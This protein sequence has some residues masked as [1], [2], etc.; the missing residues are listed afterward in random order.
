MAKGRAKTVNTQDL[1]WP[2]SFPACL[3]LFFRDVKNTKEILIK[4]EF[5]H[6]NIWRWRNG[7]RPNARTLERLEEM[8]TECGIPLEGKEL[9]DR[10]NSETTHT[11]EP[12][13]EGALAGIEA[14]IHNLRGDLEQ[15]DCNHE[16]VCKIELAKTDWEYRLAEI[17]RNAWQIKHDLRREKIAGPPVDVSAARALCRALASGAFGHENPEVL[18]ALLRSVQQALDAHHQ[19]KDK[20]TDRK[21]P[22]T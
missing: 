6:V 18:D 7:T 3:E 5:P 1:S 21:S 11:T 19:T 17:E 15:I 2:D 10:L 4:Y 14:Q 13:I 16:H 22:K 12:D 20:D 8:F 9:S